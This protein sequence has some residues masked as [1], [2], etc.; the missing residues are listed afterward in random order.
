MLELAASFLFLAFEVDW[1]SKRL[2]HTDVHPACSSVLADETE[3]ASQLG[4][5]ACSVLVDASNP[6]F[7][8]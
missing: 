8:L 3:P 7:H 5:I 2:D 4:N 1:I 6:R